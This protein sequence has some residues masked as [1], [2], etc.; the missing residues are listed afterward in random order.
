[1]TLYLLSPLG[2]SPT[3]VTKTFPL[4][5]SDVIFC[6]RIYCLGNICANWDRQLTYWSED[7][8]VEW[9]FP[10]WQYHVMCQY[11]AGFNYVILTIV[12][13]DYSNSSHINSWCSKLSLAASESMWFSF[14]TNRQSNSERSFSLFRLTFLLCSVSL[15]KLYQ[16]TSQINAQRNT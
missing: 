10:S 11:D 13:Q 3:T 14:C 1:M 4:G 9:L 2:V 7:R 15:S 8:S 12:Y 5:Y 6:D 16:E